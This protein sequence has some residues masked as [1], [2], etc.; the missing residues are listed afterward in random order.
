MSERVKANNKQDWITIL[1]VLAC[2]MILNSHCR[3]LYP[4]SFLAVGGGFGNVIFF[5][6][7]GL[8][9]VNIRYP[10]LKWYGKRVVRLLPLTLIM[11]GIS[12]LVDLFIINKD[13]LTV[14][15]YVNP[16]WFILA[17]LIYYIFYYWFIIS[18]RKENSQQAV[19]R[20]MLIFSIMYILIYALLFVLYYE[21]DMFV[22]LG[23][24][25]VFKVY[26]Y[27]ASVHIGGLIGLLRN[28]GW[29]TNE[30]ASKKK[31]LWIAV[32]VLSMMVWC[33]EYYMVYVK[34]S[35]YPLQF[36]IQ[37]GSL[38]FGIGM[39]FLGL[40]FDGKDLIGKM[41]GFLQK[42]FSLISDATL[43]IYLTQMIILKVIVY[44]DLSFPIN[45]I[46][47][48][49]SSIV[50]GIIVN[51]LYNYIRRGLFNKN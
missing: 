34:K 37:I 7:S 47:F 30:Y 39:V 48:V 12:I 35:A 21:N 24:F 49:L 41:P 1:K 27:M 29:L 26:F 6:L 51:L 32:V 2:L 36:L 16:Y 10:F 20:K 45:I 40:M 43:E 19:F 25:A 5:M 23:G 50:F 38:S 33:A 3:R 8:L 44:Y 31:L 46:T 18:L 28:R 13:K 15:D 42:L 14:R 17:M 9:L 22:E 4:V 11:T